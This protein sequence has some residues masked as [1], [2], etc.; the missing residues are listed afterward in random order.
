MPG[1]EYVCGDKFYGSPR[2]KDGRYDGVDEIDI[3]ALPY[4]DKSFDS[5]ICNHVLEHIEDDSCALSELYRVLKSGGKAI[6]QVPISY[7][8]KT[9]ED[10]SA[11]TE[12][13][14]EQTFGQIDHVRIYGTDYPAR[15]KKAG[16][17]VTDIAPE[18]RPPLTRFGVN[19]REHIYIASKK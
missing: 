6:L 11:R 13:E 17:V 16:F 14:R 1:I 3:T 2:Y 10:P 8:T 19:P 9:I 4:A 5:I 18:N 7:I 12:E 15:L